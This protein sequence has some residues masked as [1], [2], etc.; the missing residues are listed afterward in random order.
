MKEDNFSKMSYC[1]E[2]EKLKTSKLSINGLNVSLTKNFNT[3]VNLQKCKND[4]IFS[5]ISFIKKQNFIYSVKQFQEN[6]A[7]SFIA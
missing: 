2:L 3:N 4:L 6:K 5:F 7:T 1:F